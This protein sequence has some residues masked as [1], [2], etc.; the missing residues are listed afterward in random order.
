MTSGEMEQ[1]N[2]EKM[3]ELLGKQYT[4]LFQEVGTLHLYWKEFVELFGANDKRIERL[5]RAAPAFFRMIQTQQIETNILHIA[6]LTDSPKS[7]GKENLTILNLP[8]L[9]SDIALKQKLEALVEDAKRKT[10]F[11]RDWRNRQFAHHD[12]LLAT[13]DNRAV[14]LQAPTRDEFDTALAA[15]SEVMNAIER[16]YYKGPCDFGSIAAHNGAATLLW[17][18]G[19]GVKARERMEAKLAKGE[20]DEL[21]RPETI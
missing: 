18:L 7:V 12:L 8:D 16:H 11:C 1:R 19:F 4:T 20:F 10:A 9:V 14:A 6:R 21:D 13:R 17:V 3:G 5:N 15:I 2:I